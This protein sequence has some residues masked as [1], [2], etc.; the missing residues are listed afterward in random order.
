MTRKWNVLSLE[1]RHS[2]L[3]PPRRPAAV[4]RDRH[5]SVRPSGILG[6]FLG[7]NALYP[8]HLHPRGEPRARRRVTTLC[9]P[10]CTRGRTSARDSPRRPYLARLIKTFGRAESTCTLISAERSLSRSTT[11][12][13]FFFFQSSRPF[14]GG[15]IAICGSRFAAD[16][17]LRVPGNNRRIRRRPSLEYDAR[18]RREPGRG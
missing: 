13:V 11:Y 2:S 18:A 16:Y 10:V 9:E 5:L 15:Q 17:A 6:G 1:G 12:F 4:Q 7:L 8:R 14:D 3:L